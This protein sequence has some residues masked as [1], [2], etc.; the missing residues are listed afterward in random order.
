MVTDQLHAFLLA[1]WLAF[2]FCMLLYSIW[3]WWHARCEEIKEN[4]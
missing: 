3:L 1:G 4:N 2:V